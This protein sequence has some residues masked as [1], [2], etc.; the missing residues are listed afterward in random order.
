[1]N[2]NQ[3][4]NVEVTDRT[5]FLAVTHRLST[6]TFLCIFTHNQS[7]ANRASNT[8]VHGTTRKERIFTESHCSV[9]LRDDV[10]NRTG[11]N[12]SIRSAK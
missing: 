6:P 4:K 8:C 11:L 10:G 12:E 5:L 1:M 7:D 9:W 2:A 3:D